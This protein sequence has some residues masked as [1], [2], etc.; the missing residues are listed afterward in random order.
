M[1]E[2][3]KAGSALSTAIFADKENALLSFAWIS[4]CL[5]CVG[6]HHFFVLE[7]VSCAGIGAT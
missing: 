1:D 7:I 3:M 2:A 5:S 4:N 6:E